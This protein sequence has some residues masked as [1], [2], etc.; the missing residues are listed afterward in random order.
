[1]RHREHGGGQLTA[2]GTQQME[3]CET[4]ERKIHKKIPQ[5]VD[6]RGAAEGRGAKQPPVWTVRPVL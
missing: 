3:L 4:G 2:E 5:S 1:M 6:A